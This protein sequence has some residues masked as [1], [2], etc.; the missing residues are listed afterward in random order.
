MTQ[1]SEKDL[2]EAVRIG[3]TAADVHLTCSYPE[4]S[5]Q[6][7]PAAIKAALREAATALREAREL[8]TE[9]AALDECEA[10][11]EDAFERILPKVKAALRRASLDKAIRGG[12]P[13]A[14]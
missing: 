1:Q 3:C 11:I 5:C 13:A 9:I 7:L 8:L 4:C 6:R 10:H 14:G 12:P 2:V